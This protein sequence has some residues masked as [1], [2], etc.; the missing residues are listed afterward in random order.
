M[1]RRIAVFAISTRRPLGSL[2]DRTPGRAAAPVAWHGLPRRYLGGARGGAA[3]LVRIIFIML[4]AAPAYAPTRDWPRTDA[5]AYWKTSSSTHRS[6]IAA[7]SATSDLDRLRPRPGALA[8]QRAPRPPRRDGSAKGSTEGPRLARA[9]RAGVLSGGNPGPGRNHREIIRSLG[10]FG[11][12]SA[13]LTSGMSACLAA[14]P[15]GWLCR[16]W[17]KTRYGARSMLGVHRFVTR[18]RC[19]IRSTNTRHCGLGLG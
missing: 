17:Q 5:W 9:T 6:D 13:L 3:L 19:P 11:P 8:N 15:A 7:A 14:R 18:R 16:R 2:R 1:L 4:M 12:R 10:W